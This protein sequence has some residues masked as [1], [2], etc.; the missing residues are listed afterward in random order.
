MGGRYATVIKRTFNGV[1]VPVNEVRRRITYRVLCMCVLTR[2]PLLTAP[3]LVSNTHDL[4]TYNDFIAA[5]TP[6]VRSLGPSQQYN[7]CLS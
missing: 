4:N 6:R 3:Q 5:L 1:E 7:Y 2:S